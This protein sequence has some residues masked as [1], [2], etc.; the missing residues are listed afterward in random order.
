[1]SLEHP[2]DFIVNSQLLLG[3]FV[4]IVYI[5]RA[6]LLGG[7]MDGER[8]FQIITA[9]AS[10]IILPFASVI[11]YSAYDPAA[12]EWVQQ[13]DFRLSFLVLGVGALAYTV[14]NL[15]NNWPKLNP[16]G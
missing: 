3:S 9:V 15:K 1:M 8:C 10:A 13:G 2:S 14:A 11:A 5:A 12:L 4:A 16:P 6:F 7:K